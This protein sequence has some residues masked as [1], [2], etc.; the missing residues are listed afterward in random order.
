MGAVER[1]FSEWLMN[2]QNV[3]GQFGFVQERKTNKE[4]AVYPTRS[5]RRTFSVVFGG[6]ALLTIIVTRNVVSPRSLFQVK[7]VRAGKEP[8]PKMNHSQ[9]PC[10]GYI[11]CLPPTQTS[12]LILAALS[13]L[14]AISPLQSTMISAS[15][16]DRDDT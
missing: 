16:A 6:G 5:V 14:P 3:S 13:P 12:Y 2:I 15:Q 9:R 11:L 4:V 1:G 10:E 7:C 8:C